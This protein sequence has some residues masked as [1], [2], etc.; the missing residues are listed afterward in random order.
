MGP[1]Q[2]RADVG[3]V[4]VSNLTP[5]TDLRALYPF[6]PEK[7]NDL[8]VVN[9]SFVDNSATLQWSAVGDY[10]EQATGRDE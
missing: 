2:R 8:K 4:S 3:L 10:D 7:V 9:I 6:P 5:D 1:F